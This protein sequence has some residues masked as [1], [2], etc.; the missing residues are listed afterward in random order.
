M[1]AEI[2][3]VVVGILVA[4]GGGGAI[5]LALS[6]FLGKVWAERL[7]SRD[8]AAFDREL[9]KLRAELASAN[10]RELEDL[11]SSLAM[12]ESKLLGAHHEKVLLYRLV[13]DVVTEMIADVSSALAGAKVFTPADASERLH[14]F[15]RERLR[16]Y[17]YL[18]MFAPQSV[19]D[20][21]DRVIDHMFAVLEG[22]TPPDFAPIRSLGIAMLNE[23]RKDLGIDASPIAYRGTR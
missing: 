11:R 5:V 18:A 4:L 2:I 9:E 20:A 6:N 16:A 21:Y 1:A 13:G 15:E 7:M 14:R 19:M 8:K 23:I 10:A 12:S 3:Q 17:A 22:T